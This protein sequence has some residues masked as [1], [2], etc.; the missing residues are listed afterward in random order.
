MNFRPDLARKVMRGE[1]TATRRLATDNP[2]STWYRGGCKIKVGRDFA[3]CPG[4]SKHQVGRAIAS[5]VTLEPLGYLTDDEARR[6][7]FADAE[8]FIEGFR[9]INGAY[10]PDV[11]V[12]RIE[13]AAVATAPWLDDGD[14]RLFLGDS[15]EVLGCWQNAS[16]D[17]IV[18]SPP[19]GDQR[20]YGSDRAWTSGRGKADRVA[21]ARLVRPA[22]PSVADRAGL[23]RVT[24]TKNASRKQR[25]AAPNAFVPWITPFLE[26]MLRVLK[27]EGSLLLNLGR[28]MRDGEEH[29]YALDTLM[30]ARAMGWKWIDTVIWHKPNGIPLSHHSYL[31]TAHEWIWWLAPTTSA[32]RGYT[33]ET[34]RPHA[35]TTLKRITQAYD[36]PRK[37]ERYQKQGKT[38]EL[39]PDGAKPR[40]VFTHGVGGESVDHPA[41]M[42]LGVARHLVGLSSRPGD[43]VLD[44][45]VGSCTTMLAARQM[46]RRG[47][48]VD[49]H[50]PY[51][52]E[53]AGRLAQQA[54]DLGDDVGP[55]SPRPFEDVLEIVA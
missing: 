17:A 28:I 48:G 45:F 12:W 8:A 9:Q 50:E 25:S 41:I 23:A 35:E 4:R 3:V 32:Y 47:I 31:H 21:D 37:D 13:F 18:T 27:P 53:G 22:Q 20:S 33:A 54:L 43:L 29:P 2:R 46:G 44:P 39:H 10:D 55:D 49:E 15:A 52:E 14:V 34:R 36:P 24:A 30:A 6:E 5:S 16:V 26:Q 19:Y 38:H 51:L 40:S 7:G 42:A 1:K 11:E